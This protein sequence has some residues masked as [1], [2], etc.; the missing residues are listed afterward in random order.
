MTRKIAP[1]ERQAQ[2]I[3]PWLPGQREESDGQELVSTRGRLSTEG[4]LLRSSDLRTTMVGRVA[5]MIRRSS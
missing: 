2:D 4:I 3:A 1:S 5:S